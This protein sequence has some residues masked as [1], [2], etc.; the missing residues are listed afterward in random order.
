VAA[1]LDSCVFCFFPKQERADSDQILSEPF[2]ESY[3]AEE[4]VV[5]E[6]ELV[7]RKSK[8]EAELGHGQWE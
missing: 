6:L 8:D 5:W 4:P 7:L 1:I 2:E 3:A